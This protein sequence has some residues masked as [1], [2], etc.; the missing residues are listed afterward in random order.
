MRKI[1]DQKTT[2]KTPQK[3]VIYHALMTQ[4]NYLIIS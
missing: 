4:R 3:R 1:R 2:Q